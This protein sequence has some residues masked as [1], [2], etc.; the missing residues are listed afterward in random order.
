MSTSCCHLE[1]IFFFT[2]KPGN[3]VESNWDQRLFIVILR[4]PK[5]KFPVVTSLHERKFL[6]LETYTTTTK[7]PTK[8]WNMNY[9]EG[10]RRCLHFVFGGLYPNSMANMK[11]S[12]RTLK[13][14]ATYFEH[15]FYKISYFADTIRPSKTHRIGWLTMSLVNKLYVNF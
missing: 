14:L 8:Y 13:I 11:Y 1:F 9:T 4:C 7:K 3:G 12:S 10:M 6:K 15:F 5:D 2:V